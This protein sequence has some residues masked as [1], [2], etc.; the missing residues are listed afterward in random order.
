MPRY[1]KMVLALIV[2]VDVARCADLAFSHPDAID[3]DEADAGYE[4]TVG[5]V[6]WLASEGT[7]ED[8]EFSALVRDHHDPYEERR[9]Q[10][11]AEFKEYLK[12]TSF[13][14]LVNADRRRIAEAV[15]KKKETT[16][17]QKGKKKTRLRG[18]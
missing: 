1:E 6:A 2:V 14:T 9:K 4:R 13:S 5:F 10:S 16:G 12:K 8:L 15:A 17:T 3:R 7:K 18:K 11:Q